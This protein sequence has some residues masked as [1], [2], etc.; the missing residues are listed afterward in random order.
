MVGVELDSTT[1]RIAAALYPSAQIRNEGFQHTRVPEDS[2]TATVGNVPFG[3]LRLH[4]PAHNKSNL[5]IHNHFINKSLALTAPGGYV[6]V[7]SSAF[8]ADAADPRARKEMAE[9]A[10]LIGA[11]RLPTG[12]F[13]R[14]A[15]T[16]VVTDVLVFRVREE[17]RARSE[18]TAQF[19]TTGETGV[20]DDARSEEHPSEPH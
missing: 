14:V 12:A 20:R 15:G 13:A 18:A 6:A 1:A 5:S 3:A 10:D 2:F 16:E 11:V 9:Q 19:V 17:D 4:D 8:T 7:I